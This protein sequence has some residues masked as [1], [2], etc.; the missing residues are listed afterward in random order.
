MMNQ[1][2]DRWAF[3]EWARAKGFDLIAGVDEAGRGPLAGPVVAAACILPREISTEGIDDSKKLSPEMRCEIFEKL[4]HD[5]R[6][7]FGIGIVDALMIDQINILQATFEAM[8]V[9]VSKL[10]KRPA[11]LLVDGSM[12]PFLSIPSKAIPK[13]DGLSYSIGA[14]SILAK[15]TRDRLMIGYDEKWPQYGFKQHKG[16]GTKQHL[17][18]LCRFGASPIHRM[19]FEPIKSQSPGEI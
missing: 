16:Y 9:A 19:T 6:V 2:P 3:E 11:F 17:D 13:G 8:K 12:S 14:A 7:I 15:E 4:T 10:E 1:P 5:P 18:A